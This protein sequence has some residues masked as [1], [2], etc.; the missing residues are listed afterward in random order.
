MKRENVMIDERFKDNP[1]RNYISP[2]YLYK[3]I[4]L[5]F[6][7]DNDLSTNDTNTMMLRFR[8]ILEA[9]GVDKGTANKLYI[10]ASKTLKKFHEKDKLMDKEEFE[11]EYERQLRIEFEERKLEAAE[12]ESTRTQSKRKYSTPYGNPFE[13]KHPS[14]YN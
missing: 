12:P 5:N 11:R 9:N 2:S 3:F 6:K 1:A 13:I 7:E 14:P 4:S 10:V 8:G